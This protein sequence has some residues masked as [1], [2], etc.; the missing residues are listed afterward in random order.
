[1]FIKSRLTMNIPKKNTAVQLG[2]VTF[3][4]IVMV[5]RFSLTIFASDTNES[6]V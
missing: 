2:V 4:S 5:T 3:E 1:M 6:I